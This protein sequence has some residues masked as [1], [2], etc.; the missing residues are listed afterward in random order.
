MWQERQSDMNN[1]VEEPLFESESLY[2]LLDGAALPALQI[3]YQHDDEPE[4]IPL[5]RGTR[6]AASMESSPVLYKLSE[7]KY[8]WENRAR[9]RSAAIVLGSQ[10]AMEALADHLRS[11]LSVKL[12]SGELVFCRFYDPA[13]TAR[14]LSSLTED[15]RSAW[16]GPIKNLWTLR[17]DDQWLHFGASYEAPAMTPDDEGWFSLRVEQLKSWQEEERRLFIQ[18]LVAHFSSDERCS[19]PHADLEKLIELRIE[20]AEQAGIETEQQLFAFVELALQFPDAMDSPSVH[21]QL[22]NMDESAEHR[23]AAIEASLL[24]LNG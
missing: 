4:A 3:I 23:L 20:Q 13:L 11:L 8:L 10:S 24:G 14:F 19:T 7:Q 21:K 16:L 18:R 2:L 9:W 17:Q 15:E 22:T 6:H 12:P 5:Y 1:Q